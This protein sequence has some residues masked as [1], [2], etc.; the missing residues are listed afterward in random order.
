MVSWRSFS[1][2]FCWNLPSCYTSTIFCRKEVNY[3]NFEKKEEEVL[4]EKQT[5]E[6]KKDNTKCVFFERLVLSL[7]QTK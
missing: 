4:V 3:L 2:Y 6:S 7:Y 5:G 1:Y